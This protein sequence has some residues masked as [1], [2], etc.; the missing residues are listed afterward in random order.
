[1][2]ISS[3]VGGLVSLGQIEAA[4][5]NGYVSAPAVT[6]WLEEFE[7]IK[8]DGV[9]VGN[10]L[11]EVK[12]LIEAASFPSGMVAENYQVKK[13]EHIP[14]PSIEGHLTA[15]RDLM[16]V[17]NLLNDD[18]VSRISV[19]G[20]GGVGKTT[21]VKN[22]NKK[23]ETATSTEP[24]V[25]T[26]ESTESTASR[27]HQRVEK[28]RFLLILDDVWEVIDFDYLG[29][30]WSEPLMGYKIILTSRSLDVSQNIT[31]DIEEVCKECCGLPLALIIVGAFMR[32]KIAEASWKGALNA[33]QRELV[34]CWIAEG[35]V[36]IRRIYEDSINRGIELVENLKDSCMLE[37]GIFKDTV[38]M[39]EVLPEGMEN[40]PNL[41]QLDLSGTRRLRHIGKGIIIP[42]VPIG[43]YRP[44]KYGD[45]L[46]SRNLEEGTV[47]YCSFYENASL[48]DYFGGLEEDLPK[49]LTLSERPESWQHLDQLEAVRCNPIKKLPFATQNANTKKEIRGELQWWDHLEWDDEDTKSRHFLKL[50]GGQQEAAPTRLVRCFVG[51]VRFNSAIPSN[52]LHLLVVAALIATVTFAAAFTI[53]GGHNNDIGSPNQGLALIQSTRLF[54]WFIISDSVA[55]TCS[56]T[57]A[58][59]IF[60]G[61]VVAKETYVYYFASARELTYIALLSTAT[62]FTAGVVAVLPDQ[63]FINTMTKI[64]GPFFHVNTF[65]ILFQEDDSPQIEPIGSLP[66]DSGVGHHAKYAI[67]SSDGMWL[68]SPVEGATYRLDYDNP[69]APS[70][71]HDRCSLTF[72]I[73]KVSVYSTSN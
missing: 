60:G 23:L 30:P 55:M 45:I 54:K 22:F 49:L 33:L 26:G 8:N 64:V 42:A 73:D 15:S 69:V 43:N 24:S 61:A 50:S 32:G 37:N 3:L 10:K 46:T 9:K 67:G 63:P 21:P 68:F 27:L 59:I 71:S 66:P 2:A 44:D 58:C 6:K 57:A 18:S 1:M 20:M 31:T 5:G 47:G 72:P 41:S 38:K 13:V 40:L 16:K 70:D 56:I 12:R 17:L 34:R 36:Y 48:S 7:D 39:H 19:W 65:L 53:P 14:G 62:P 29:V 35:L 4:K 28:E 11:I 51:E 25:K 52:G